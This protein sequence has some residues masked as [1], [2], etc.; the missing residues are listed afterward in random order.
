MEC[1]RGADT[2]PPRHRLAVLLLANLSQAGEGCAAILQTGSALAGL[3]FRRLIQLFLTGPSG[4]GGGAASTPQSAAAGSTGDAF[5]HLASVL[6]NVSKLE[7]ARTILMDAERGIAPG[8]IRQ[9]IVIGRGGGG[10][11]GAGRFFG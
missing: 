3:Q 9:L 10:G 2:T 6:Q 5:E 11:G 8:L 1:L 4:S 7:A